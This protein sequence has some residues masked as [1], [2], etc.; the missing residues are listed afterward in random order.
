[1]GER[2]AKFVFRRRFSFFD[3]IALVAVTVAIDNLWL[4]I[5]ALFVLAVLG[6]II[7]D[8]LGLNKEQTK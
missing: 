2:I 1:M 8:G 6:D 3:V 7:H 5:G 4:R